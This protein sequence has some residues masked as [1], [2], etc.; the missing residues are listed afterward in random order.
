MAFVAIVD[1]ST[2]KPISSPQRASWKRWNH[3]KYL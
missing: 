3:Y 2:L 1:Y